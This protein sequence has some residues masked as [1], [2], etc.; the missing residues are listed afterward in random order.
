M[1]AASANAQGKAAQQAAN[2]NAEAAKMEA[3]SRAGIQREQARRQLGTIRS[4]IGKS[5]A[6][7]AGTPLTVLADS[8]AAAEA[9]ALNT[10]LTG[11]RQ[12]SIYRAQGA[13][14]RMQG[15]IGAGATLLSGFGKIF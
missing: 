3:A 5:G 12:S 14:A 10:E 6:T 8:A 9:D 7:S 2:Y 4:Q 15:R 1:A 13:N 11:A